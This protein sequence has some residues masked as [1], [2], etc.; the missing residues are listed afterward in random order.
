MAFLNKFLDRFVNEALEKTNSFFDLSQ[1]WKQSNDFVL[2]HATTNFWMLTDTEE[3][4][5]V[6]GNKNYKN[7]TISYETNNAGYRLTTRKEDV[8]DKKIIACFG[9]S[10]TFGIGLKYE[11]TWPSILEN[12]LGANFIAHNYGVPG[13]S[14]DTIARLIHNYLLTETPAAICCL[15]PDMFRREMFDSNSLTVPKNYSNLYGETDEFTISE[16]CKK[17]DYNIIDFRSYKRLSGEENSI[18]NFI[19]N[20][21]LIETLCLMNN[22]PLVLTT[23]DIYIL[24]CLKLPQNKKTFNNF[25]EPS[26]SDFDF[27]LKWDDMEKSRDGIHLGRAPLKKHAELLYDRLT[28]LLQI[29]Q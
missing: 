29:S 14:F 8:S 5:K 9:C 23:W 3:N 28:S 20:L 2:T 12:M 10:Q 4:F 7:E 25:V 13:A 17:H 11:D 19:K 16:L 24:N 21:K 27:F 18:F 22:I 1:H 15:L 26:E 6:R